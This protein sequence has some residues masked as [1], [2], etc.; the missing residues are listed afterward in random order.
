MKGAAV[1]M[2]TAALCACLLVLVG[3]ATLPPAPPAGGHHAPKIELSADGR[4]ARLELDVLTYNIEGVPGRGGRAKQLREIG[5]Q[6]RRL[7]ESGEGP[8]IILFQEAFSGQAQ[9]AIEAAGY[10]DLAFGPSRKQ[11]RRLPG[12]GPRSG[13]KWSKGELG[14]KLVGS[15]LVI[16]SV[17]PIE[18]RASEPFSRRACA[19]FDCLSNKG[20]LFARIRIPGAPDPLEVFD[21]HMN[22][23]GASQVS[24]RRHLPVH[25]AQVFELFDFMRERHDAAN[26][27]LLG[28]DFNMRRSEPRF[29]VFRATQRLQLVHEYCL[30]DPKRCDVRMSWDGDEPWMDTQDLQLFQSGRRVTVRPIRVESLFD[31]RPGSPLLSD[32]D[33]YRVVYELSWP[34]ATSRDLAIGA[35]ER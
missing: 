32:H 5:D 27:V 14:L 19:G 22:A 35:Q 4:T 3:C 11:R 2:R 23:Q 30:Q 29:G 21:T 15:G 31:G 24:V 10:P 18:A 8:D 7:R 17:Y 26:P 33:G 6:L 20:A 34:T 9:A 1:I 28:G 25:R 16:A 12:A 13:H